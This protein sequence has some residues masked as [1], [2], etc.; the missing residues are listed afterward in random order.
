MTHSLKFEDKVII[1]V[2]NGFLLGKVASDSIPPFDLRRALKFLFKR[3]RFDRKINKPEIPIEK[4][5]LLI[6]ISRLYEIPE[7]Q[8][9]VTSKKYTD[10][11]YNVV[12]KVLKEFEIK[13]EEFNYIR[14]NLTSEEIY[15]REQLIGWLL[16]E[17]QNPI[18][19]DSRY[20]LGFR[21]VSY[22]LRNNLDKI[23]GLYIAEVNA[24]LKP[25]YDTYKYKSLLV[26]GG[27]I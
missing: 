6:P 1:D 15:N 7:F 19:N 16:R 12:I 4:I 8:S 20:R 18:P 5:L 14:K 21:S 9:D 3:E 26:P 23:N 24:M 27:N 11:F 2:V 22:I 25:F 10:A 13:D 17:K